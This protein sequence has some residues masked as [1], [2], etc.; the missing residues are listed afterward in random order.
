MST[1]NRG[2]CLHSMLQPHE[3]NPERLATFYAFNLLPIE[4]KI[5]TSTMLIDGLYICLTMLNNKDNMASKYWTSWPVILGIG[6]PY[7][8]EA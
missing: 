3:A 1:A 4:Q 5:F 7:P 6:T 8:L 2:P